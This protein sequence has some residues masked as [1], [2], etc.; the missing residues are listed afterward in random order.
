MAS[1]SPIFVVNNLKMLKFSEYRRLLKESQ[2]RKIREDA[3]AA[4]GGDG[5]SA[6]GAGEISS[7]SGGF[8]PVGDVVDNTKSSGSTMGTTS[9]DVLGKC[10]HEHNKDGIFGPGCFHLPFLFGYPVYRFQ[11]SKRKG[12]NRKNRKPRVL[13]SDPYRMFIL[14]EQESEDFRIQGLEGYTVR[15]VLEFARDFLEEKTKECQMP[16]RILDL[17]IIG[18]RNRHTANEDSDLDVAFSYESLDGEDV[19]DDA[20]FDVV[21]EE[22]KFT[23]DGIELDFNPQ[24][25]EDTDFEDY[26]KRAHEYDEY[27]LGT[28]TESTE[29]NTKD[30]GSLV[31][32]QRQ[33]Q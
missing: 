7:P 10:D 32:C 14:K 15:E 17:A 20:L 2:N 5:G 21:N 11:K 16:V 26:L 13:P 24:N 3:V 9:C 23:I 31:S 33:P 25:A 18:S 19:R 28:T 6:G 1:F 4:P 12:K 22:P 8:Q 30:E 29:K 27:V